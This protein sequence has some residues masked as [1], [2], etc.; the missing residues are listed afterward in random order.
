[1]S[2][3]E[4][5]DADLRREQFSRFE[6]HSS[7]AVS[8]RPRGSSARGHL[9]NSASRARSAGTRQCSISTESRRRTVPVEI[10]LA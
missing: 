10:T 7:R 8:R 2:N 1:M 9:A 3:A 6:V 4:A 5:R